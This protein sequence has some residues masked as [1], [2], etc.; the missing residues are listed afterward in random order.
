MLVPEAPSSSVSPTPVVASKEQSTEPEEMSS[1]SLPTP[2]PVDQGAIELEVLP[3]GSSP[4]H[5]APL[6]PIFPIEFLSR[7]LLRNLRGPCLMATEVAYV[8]SLWLIDSSNRD[9]EVARLKASLASVQKE[10]DE[11][12]VKR[13][14]LAELCQE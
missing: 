8:L 10:R 12:L 4:L 5:E 6:F 7:T 14:E 13:D 9:E 3:T 11:A 2:T 1:P